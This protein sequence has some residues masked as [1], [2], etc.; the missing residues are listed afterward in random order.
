MRFAPRFSKRGDSSLNAFWDAFRGCRANLLRKSLDL[1]RGLIIWRLE[2]AQS[3]FR[4]D[5]L[6]PPH[7]TDVTGD[8][9]L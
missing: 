6:K 9:C 7:R 1:R 3:Q 5:I 4:F 2:T 8:K